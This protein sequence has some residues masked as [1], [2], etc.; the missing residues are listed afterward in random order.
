M[1]IFG[2]SLTRFGR[3]M[4]RFGRSMTRFGRSVTRFGRSMSFFYVQLPTLFYL[5]QLFLHIPTL[6][7]EDEVTSS[8]EYFQGT[9]TDGGVRFSLLIPTYFNRSQLLLTNPNFFRTNWEM[10]EHIWDMYV[11]NWDMYV[12]TWD[13]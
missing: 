2:R 4:T 13:M 9:K 7:S 11:M 5:S 1:Y 8:L 3:S 6:V 10:Y 12:R